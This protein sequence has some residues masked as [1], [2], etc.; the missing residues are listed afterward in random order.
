MA[1]RRC[2]S[3][4]RE[5]ARA[6]LPNGQREKAKIGAQGGVSRLG[7]WRT[8]ETV[9]PQRFQYSNI[10]ET[11]CGMI[12]G[13]VICPHPMAASLMLCRLLQQQ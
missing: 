6:A 1:R 10:S 9:H 12:E 7:V 13:T 11:S 2:E 5:G 3:M 4:V 8:I